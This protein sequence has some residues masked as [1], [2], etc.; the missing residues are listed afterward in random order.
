MLHKPVLLEEVLRYLDLKPGMVVV[1]G[2][3]GGGGHAEAMMD[4]I[5]TQ[6]LLVGFDQ[7]EEAIERCRKRFHGNE[8]V[9]ICRTNF[10]NMEFALKEL[11][12]SK[13]DA[14]LL[15]VGISSFQIDEGRRGFSFQKEGPLDM[16]MN[17]AEGLTAADLVNTLPADQL[18]SIIFEWGEERFARKIT[19]AICDRRV[20]K[21]FET[22]QDLAEAIER[23]VPRRGRLHPA[24]RT[25]QALRIAVNDE[26]GALEEGLK[27]GFSSLVPG[28]KMAVIS[29]HSL[30]ER[31][32]KNFF[33]DKMR[34]SEG[35]LINKKPITPSLEEMHHNPRSRSA[36]LRVVEKR[37]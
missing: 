1:D 6:G 13:V 4:R 33:R 36:K 26:L 2:T 29:F 22:T 35:L 18:N 30:E 34:L 5:A 10:R 31:L 16:R 28:G 20:K 15:D 21:K 32:V 7:D 27:A 3:L 14:V 11:D 9:R 17:S 19:R 37:L 25:F 8:R 23:A 24:T 12:I